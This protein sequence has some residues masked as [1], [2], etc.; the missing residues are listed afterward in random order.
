MF[1]KLYIFIDNVQLICVEFDYI[2][3]KHINRQYL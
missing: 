3:T 1:D 2:V